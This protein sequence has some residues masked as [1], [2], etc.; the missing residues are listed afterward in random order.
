MSGDN[1]G[2]FPIEAYFEMDISND[3]SRLERITLVIDE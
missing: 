1:Q 3:I 2:G